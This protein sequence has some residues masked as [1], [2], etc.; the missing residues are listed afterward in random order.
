[1]MTID[2]LIN[3]DNATIHELSHSNVGRSSENPF[4]DTPTEEDEDIID[5][6]GDIEDTSIDIEGSVDMD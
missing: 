5:L 6:M 2:A 4:D 1:M 3:L